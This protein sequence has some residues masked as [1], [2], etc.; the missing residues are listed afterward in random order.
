LAQFPWFAF[1]R[2]RPVHLNVVAYGWTAMAGV[3]LTTWMLPRLLK[4]PLMGSG[5]SVSGAMVW[6]LALYSGILAIL[7]GWTNGLEWLEFP[8][9]IGVLFTFGGGFAAVPLIL[10][11][12]RRKVDHLYVTIWY[13]GAALLWFPFLYLVANM[14][15]IHFG[16]EGAAMNWWYGHNVLGYFMTPMAVGVAYYFI[17]K[18]LGEP[19]HSYNLSVVGFWTLAL[20]YGQVGMHHLIGGPIPSWV[21]TLSIVQSMMMLLPIVAFFINMRNT[22]Q[23]HYRT[24]AYS[25]TMRFIFFGGVC[26]ILASVQGSFEALR[27]MNTVVHFT[28]YTIGH[29]HLGLYAFVAMIFFGAIYFVMPRILNWEWPYPKLIMVHFWLVAIGAVTYIAALSIGGWL[30]GL[31]MLDENHPF[32]DSVRVT[33]PYLTARSVG[34]AL[35]TLGHIIFALHFYIMVLRHGPQRS[36]A[37]V[38]GLPSLRGD[39]AGAKG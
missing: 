21:V 34:G 32:M 6:N 1:G 4:T 8:W 29:A 38:I 28:H 36:V 10:T 12:I 16:V 39:V 20:F 15:Y 35:M 33:L 7:L 3:G 31:L 23:G 17:P 11:V 13:C 5:Y 25:P 14:P 2:I 27:S 18:V 22:M 30:Q 26:Y 37:A 24:V 9:P 19:I